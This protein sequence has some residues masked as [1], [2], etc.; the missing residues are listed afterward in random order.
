MA[1]FIPSSGLGFVPWGASD[2]CAK[3]KAAYK[4]AR[5]YTWTKTILTKARADAHKAWLA[6]GKEYKACKA[7]KGIGTFAPGYPPEKM[8]LL[9]FN[10]R[11]LSPAGLLGAA[12]G[13]LA[14]MQGARPVSM[15]LPEWEKRASIRGGIKALQVIGAQP[16][17]GRTSADGITSGWIN[18]SAN[19]KLLLKTALG[20]K[21]TLDKA[22]KLIQK[23][24]AKHGKSLSKA[25]WGFRGMYMLTDVKTAGKIESTA[26][27][28]V[29]AIPLVG[30]AISAAVAVK[31]GIT[32]VVATNTLV[33]MTKFAQEGIA[34]CRGDAKCMPR[35]PAQ[36]GAPRQ[37]GGS[38]PRGNM[39]APRGGG[40]SV[41]SPAPGGPASLPWIPWAL[42]GVAVVGILVYLSR[43]G[44]A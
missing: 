37:P 43:R 17:A 26:G 4:K 13:L 38:A 14:V 41:P 9:P 11:K 36:P 31:T 16:W 35:D 7:G 1:V 23:E 22:Y 32:S 15:G 19:E 28:V 30:W 24:V 21:G 5:D 42:G 39:P 44:A 20:K 18:L 27:S 34:A 12:E 25:A 29:M 10:K 8:W 40:A 2:P 33:M 3:Q 6:R